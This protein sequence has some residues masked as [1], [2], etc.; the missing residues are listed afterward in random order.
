MNA[1]QD[2]DNDGPPDGWWILCLLGGSPAFLFYVI[3]YQNGLKGAV[4]AGGIAS[5]LFAAG[6]FISLLRK[7]LALATV[8][9]L[10]AVNVIGIA[11]LP[12]SDSGGPGM[13]ILFP[14]VLVDCGMC[15]LI[16]RFA[17]SN[18]TKHQ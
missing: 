5:V 8:L 16:M 15:Y 3:A 18:M 11:Y 1:D 4:M 17:V 13:P 14:F 12:I 10:L 6:F 9:L 7:P 2:D